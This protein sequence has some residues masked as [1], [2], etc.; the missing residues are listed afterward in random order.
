LIVADSNV[1][2]PSYARRFLCALA[3]AFDWRL[4]VVPEL[5]REFPRVLARELRRR[6]RQRPDR[7]KHPMPDDVDG[8]CE[9]IANRWLQ[10]AIAHDEA[11]LTRCCDR[12]NQM[13]RATELSDDSELAKAFV[14]GRVAPRIADENIVTQSLAAGAG[15]IVTTNMATIDHKTVNDYARRQGANHDVLLHPSIAIQHLIDSA[16][17]K[18]HR[19]MALAALAVSVSD[20]NREDQAEIESVLHFLRFAS[21][22]LEHPSFLA[23]RA[24]SEAVNQ[25]GASSMLN[26]AREMAKQGPWQ[27]IRSLESSM[28]NEIRA[29][30]KANA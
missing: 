4:G 7:I 14:D 2:S 24:I 25:R 13:D 6:D 23:R 5:E 20:K 19:R 10:S 12:P 27:A 9:T 1:L 30:G 11:P 28:R 18:N 3:A 26:E 8:K 17:V 22:P 29:M 16:L 15:F 21:P